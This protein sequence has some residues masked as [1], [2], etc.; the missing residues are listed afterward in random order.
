MR[1]N[2]FWLVTSGQAADV[3]M[4]IKGLGKR[5]S[6]GVTEKPLWGVPEQPLP[7]CTGDEEDE[8]EDMT[9]RESTIISFVVHLLS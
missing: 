7:R 5:C 6:L 4:N 2:R 8:R 1:V 3:L 9:E